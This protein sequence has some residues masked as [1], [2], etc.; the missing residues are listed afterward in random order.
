MASHVR[1]LLHAWVDLISLSALAPDHTWTTAHWA[2]VRQRRTHTR[3]KRWL[4]QLQ[5]RR[6]SARLVSCAVSVK[7][8]FNLSPPPSCTCPFFACFVLPTLVPS[9]LLQHHRIL[10]TPPSHACFTPPSSFSLVLYPS[11]RRVLF[12]IAFQHCTVK[13]L[14]VD[15]LTAFH[16]QEQRYHD[17]GCRIHS[18]NIYAAHSESLPV[19]ALAATLA[20]G[21]MRPAS[22]LPTIK[23]SSCGQEIEIAAMGNHLCDGSPSESNLGHLGQSSNPFALTQLNASGQAFSN[24]PSPVHQSEYTSQASTRTPDLGSLFR[25]PSKMSRSALPRI[26]PEAANQPFLAPMPAGLDSPLSPVS[27]ARSGKPSYYRS[28]T[29]PIPRLFDPRPP[30]PELSANLDCAFPPFPTSA[31]SSRP[32]TSQG[33]RTPNGSERTPS[34]G[35]SRLDHMLTVEPESLSLEPKSPM[36]NA[37]ENVLQKLNTLKSG[38]FAGARTPVG[39]PFRSESRRPSAPLGNDDIDERDPGKPS[40]PRSA[41]PDDE[42]LT[43]SFLDQFS[44][45]PISDVAPAFGQPDSNL[46][47]GITYFPA[48]DRE[49]QRPDSQTLSKVRSEPVLKST[50]RRP[51]LANVAVSGLLPMLP[52]H[53]HPPRGESRSA[54]RMDHRLQDAPPVPRP[55]IRSQEASLH[56]PSESG[57]SGASATRSSTYTEGTNKGN[58]NSFG[59]SS[60]SSADAFSPLGNSVRDAG[61]SSMHVPGLN[62]RNPQKP[63]ERAELPKEYSPPRAFTRRAPSTNLAFVP[64]PVE[65][66]MDPA[67]QP[68]SGS[69]TSWIPCAQLQSN[70]TQRLPPR[71]SSRAPAQSPMGRLPMTPTLAMPQDSLPNYR[72]GTAALSPMDRAQSPSNSSTQYTSPSIA[73]SHDLSPDTVSSQQSRTR[74]SPGRRPTMSSKPTCRGCGLVIEGK[75]VKAADGRLTGRWH[76]QCFTCKICHQGFLTADFYVIDNDPYCE[77][78]YH[79]QNGSLCQGCHRGIEGQYLETTSTTRHGRDDKKYHPRC[80]TCCECRSVLS[81]DYFEIRNRVYCERHALAAMRAQ[82]RMGGGL[83]PPGRDTFAE[84]RTTRLIN[85]MMP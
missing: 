21:G 4:S 64:E 9:L 67:L 18:Y 85:P 5:A 32:S 38:P 72:S 75:S 69:S 33:R 76:K 42:V 80:F 29:S 57:S 50:E 63:G 83:V 53:T 51:S 82:A 46:N 37:G 54:I 28:A 1:P 2:A 17:N 43:P 49:G 44:A 68:L 12:E 6:P 39:L 45:E 14:D 60:T 3:R 22:G 47:S 59:G 23:C 10:S 24:T 61:Q 31:T 36:T 41:R 40:R 19:M 26:N 55:S 71:T 52:K 13:T 78:D 66:P 20:A 16:T 27:S 15:H 35:A 48:Q 84:R 81:D 62:L 30:S 34:R 65:S 58:E 70:Q 7:L 74:R 25:G 11:G 77:H 8:N 56:T 73:G 79:E